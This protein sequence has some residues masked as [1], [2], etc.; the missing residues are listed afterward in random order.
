MRREH[1]LWRGFWL[2]LL[3]TATLVLLNGPDT[4]AAFVGDRSALMSALAIAVGASLASLPGRLRRRGRKGEPIRWQRCL[5]AFGA[6]VMMMV[7]LALAGSGRILASLYE[8][9]VAAFAFVG[10]AWLAGLI[11]VRIRERGRCP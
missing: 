6:G 2:A 11:T 1:P 3:L 9:S 8:G 5:L 7:G 4:T 10:L